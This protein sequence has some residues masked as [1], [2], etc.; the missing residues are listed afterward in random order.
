MLVAEYEGFFDKLKSFF[1]FG[2]GG[3]AKSAVAPSWSGRGRPW[4]RKSIAS[5]GKTTPSLFTSKRRSFF[6]GLFSRKNTTSGGLFSSLAKEFK[7]KFPT[8]TTKTKT[9]D[10]VSE[11]K[12]YLK[13]TS[14]SRGAM[15]S[16]PSLGFGKQAT[17]TIT[18]INKP[19]TS[20]LFSHSDLFKT[21][22]FGKITQDLL[23]KY[24]IKP[25]PTVT[26]TYF[27]T[28]KH[29]S[30]SPLG[31]YFE[32]LWKKGIAPALTLGVSYATQRAILKAA[33]VKNVDYILAQQFGLPTYTE[34]A[35]TQGTTSVTT[36]AETYQPTETTASESSGATSQEQT[37]TTT[38][39]TQTK[40]SQGSTLTLNN[41]TMLFLLGGLA[42]ALLLSRR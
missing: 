18:G 24:N 29:A 35:T 3:G 11:A 19:Q 32:E 28:S 6:G 16:F 30:K 2:G 4:I 27:P 26:P 17:I 37:T 22:D 31:K 23:K 21:P 20:S 1:H 14:T 41:K 8:T 39:N 13:S 36:S 33:G 34:T 15:L 9:F 10:V 40:S 5:T 25:L 12:K 7:L 38:T 42:L